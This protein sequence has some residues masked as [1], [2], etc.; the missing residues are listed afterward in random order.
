MSTLYF[1]YRSAVSTMKAL[2]HRLG[3]AHL[4]EDAG[5]QGAWDM[6]LSPEAYHTGIAVLT[7]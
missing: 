1:T 4:V 2:F 5:K 6:L 7:R 3:G